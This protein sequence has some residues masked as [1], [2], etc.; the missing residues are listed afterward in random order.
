MIE[1]RQEGNQTLVSARLVT[2]QF[3]F[4]APQHP[5]EAEWSSDDA[6]HPS[7]IG[8]LLDGIEAEY[9]VD[10]ARVCIGGV[11]ACCAVTAD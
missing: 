5:A 8:D 1:K 9:A 6:F 7:K 11:R 2:E 10:T 3:L 4:V